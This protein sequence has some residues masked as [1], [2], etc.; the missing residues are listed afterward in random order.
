[1]LTEPFTV[2]HSQHCATAPP[3]W[4]SPSERGQEK[5][6]SFP[7]VYGKCGLDLTNMYYNSRLRKGRPEFFSDPSSHGICQF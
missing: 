7:K 5:E 4:L 6:I 1:M 3:D 2:S